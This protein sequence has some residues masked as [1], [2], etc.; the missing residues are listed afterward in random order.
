MVDVKVG[1]SGEAGAPL[2]PN[3]PTNLPTV[4]GILKGHDQLQ[5]LVLDDVREEYTGACESQSTTN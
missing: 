1:R 4:I 3:P 2:Q 5:N